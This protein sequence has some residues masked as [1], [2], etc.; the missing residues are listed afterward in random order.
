MEDPKYKVSGISVDIVCCSCSGGYIHV[1]DRRPVH[2]CLVFGYAGTG[3]HSSGSLATDLDF[4]PIIHK[5]G[6]DPAIA[7][8]AFCRQEEL[9][10]TRVDLED[11][12]FLYRSYN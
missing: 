5:N 10:W 6:L 3:V 2:V 7:Y 1:E 9:Y 12:I 11:S 4:F 8:I